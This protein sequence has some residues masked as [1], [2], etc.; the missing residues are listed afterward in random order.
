MDR[1]D[2]AFAGAD[3]QARMI[4]RG[5]V[6]SRELVELYLERIERLDPALNAYRVVFGE[7]AL[8]EAAQADARRRGGDVRPLLGVPIAV[9]D[10]TDVS[11]EITLHGA[12][13]HVCLLY[14]SP[15]PRD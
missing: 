14:T 12:H 11:G 15:S 4:K 6:S 10:D 8:A 13:A 2:L 3:E 5:E 1:T 9:K 7:R